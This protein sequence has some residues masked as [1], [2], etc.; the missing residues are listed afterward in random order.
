MAIATFI[1]FLAAFVGIGLASVRVSRGTGADYYL[2]SRSVSAPLAG[3]SAVATNNSGYMFIGVIGYTYA[4]GLA[5][6]W[7]MLGWILGDYLASRWIHPRLRRAAAADAELSFVGLIC[8][9][10]GAPQKGL[11]RVL[12]L[13]TLIFLLAYT[14]AQLV[15]GSKAL[16]GLFH[17]PQW[18]GAVLAAA[19]VL[20]YSSVGGLRASIW[21]DAAQ[22]VVMM[23]AMG[24]LLHSAL[25]AAGGLAGAWAALAGVDHMLEWFPAGLAWPGP[26]GAGLFVLGWLFA[27]FSVIGQPHIMIRFMALA[28]DDGLSRTRAW[29][30]SWFTLFYA[31]ATGVGLLSRVLISDPGDFDPELALPVLAQQLLPPAGVGLILAGVFA[32][33]LSTADSLVLSCSSALTRDL[34]ATASERLSR[35]KGATAVVVLTALG[36]ALL[37]RDGV[38]AIVIFSW[39]GLASTLG[40]V[41]VL[42]ALGVDV[43][44]RNGVIAAGAG[45]TVAICWRLLGWHTTVVYEGMPGILAGVVSG[46]LARTR[47]FGN[48]R[49]ST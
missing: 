46:W 18:C 35:Y 8:D 39:S 9:W 33:T 37:G 16:H 21:T 11:R 42:R 40:P 23:V 27:G 45:V 22:S 31:M 29:Y 24:V 32:A 41:L 38:F 7:L 25:G 17:W 49:L 1:L 20:G 30:Y 47:R 48:T 26:A 43:K 14:G 4:T 3:L 2:A 15:A 5:S 44:F 6:I 12:G 28:G 36:W 19:L 10:N 34:P 13:I